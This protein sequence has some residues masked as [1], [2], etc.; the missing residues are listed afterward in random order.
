MP[1]RGEGGAVGID[2][3]T[4]GD[5]RP[6]R[7]SEAEDRPFPGAPDNREPVPE[8]KGQPSMDELR[9]LHQRARNSA[10]LVAMADA[11]EEGGFAAALS[12]D[13][14]GEGTTPD[15]RPRTQGEDAEDTQREGADP[16]RGGIDVQEAPAEIVGAGGGPAPTGPDGDRDAPGDRHSGFTPDQDRWIPHDDESAD[17]PGTIFGRDGVIDAGPSAG[18]RESEGEEEE[19]GDAG[20]ARKA[21]PEAQEQPRH[22]DGA[23]ET[24]SRTDG[25]VEESKSSDQ[26]GERDPGAEQTRERGQSVQEAHQESVPDA[27]GDQRMDAF[28]QRMQSMMEQKLQE[29]LDGVRAEMKA[30][31]EAKLEEQKAEQKAEYEAQIES[32]KADYDAKF[33]ELEAKVEGGRS[34]ADTSPDRKPDG[35]ENPDVSS[36]EQRGDRPQSG[37]NAAEDAPDSLVSQEQGALIEGRE[38]TDRES[39]ANREEPGR[40]R[41]MVTSTRV[42]AAGTVASAVNAA[43]MLGVHASPESIAS[44]GIA[45][46]GTASLGIAKLE[47]RRKEKD[48]RQH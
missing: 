35:N 23:G 39:D 30:D 17:G 14:G 9:V 40:L 21:R 7:Y 4:G 6:D 11:Y 16:V 1:R 32:I 27:V 5:G 33:D 20:A 15:A 38:G 24:A 19:R 29:A 36:A 43:A 37:V 12:V 44:L 22:P 3:P 13:L 2:R 42:G 8:P 47:K 31:Y 25:S 34:N 41:R 26:P 46:V 45:L 10:D 48:G 28:E 18:I